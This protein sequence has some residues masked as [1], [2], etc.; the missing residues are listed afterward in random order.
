MANLAALLD[1]EAGAEIEAILSEARQRA[2]EIVARAKEEAKQ[3]VSLKERVLASEHE[4]AIVRAKSAAQLEASA[5]KLR[6]QNEAVQH[7]FNQVEDTINHL[8]KDKNNYGG[9]L[10]NLF[11]EASEAVGK[12]SSI[13]VNPADKDLI[14][15]PEGVKVETDPSLIAGVRLKGDKSNAT[16]ENTLGAR[17]DTLR[18]E[19]ASD[20]YKLLLGK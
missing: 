6:T 4:A 2:S 1:R 7:V 13:V 8:V 11:K 16:I 3:I 20:V 5:L 17:L 10:N 18:G 12:V 9:V 15:A 19:L 14:K